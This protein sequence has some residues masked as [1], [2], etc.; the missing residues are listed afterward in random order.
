MARLVHVFWS[1]SPCRLHL[2]PNACSPSCISSS[3]FV[4]F[5][6][7]SSSFLPPGLCLR[8]AL[9][10]QNYPSCFSGRLRIVQIS[11]QTSWERFWPLS[12]RTAPFSLAY[13]IPSFLSVL[14]PFHYDNLHLFICWLSSYPPPPLL[15]S[16]HHKNKNFLFQYYSPLYPLCLAL[17]LAHRRCSTISTGCWVKATELLSIKTAVRMFIG[18]LHDFSPCFILI[19]TGYLPWKYILL[20]L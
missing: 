7:L 20:C 3:P 18:Y 1:W 16:K 4:S 17:C 9:C 19:H 6:V 12:P 11:S 5:F 2:V 8:C 14:A 13:L 10:Q 15:D